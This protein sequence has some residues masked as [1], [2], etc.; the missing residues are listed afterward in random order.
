MSYIL[1]LYAFMLLTITFGRLPFFKIH[2]AFYFIFRDKTSQ[3]I[4]FSAFFIFS[5]KRKKE[6][7][8][9]IAF[10]ENNLQII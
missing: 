1:Q 7:V 3:K 9:L 5:V 10:A 6:I 2:K 4:I 8:P